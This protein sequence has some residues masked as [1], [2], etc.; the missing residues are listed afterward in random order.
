MIVFVKGKPKGGGHRVFDTSPL[1]RLF[2][3]RVCNGGLLSKMETCMRI[4]RGTC[5][6]RACSATPG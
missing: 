6:F 4:L 1:L 5:I 3:L 2:D